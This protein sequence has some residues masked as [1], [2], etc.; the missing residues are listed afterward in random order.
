MEIPQIYSARAQGSIGLIVG[1]MKTDLGQL[2]GRYTSFKR[3]TK[4]LLYGDYQGDIQEH[5]YNTN[6]YSHAQPC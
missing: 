4:R 5:I 1:V 6:T 2:K 3:V